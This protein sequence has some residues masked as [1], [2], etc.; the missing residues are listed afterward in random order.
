MPVPRVGL[1]VPLVTVPLTALE[2]PPETAIPG[3]AIPE[4]R[5]SPQ[6]SRDGAA[7]SASSASRPQ[8][9]GFFQPTAQPSRAATGT[10]LGRQVLPVQRISH[11]GAQRVASTEPARHPAGRDERVPRS[12]SRVPAREQL[13]AALPGVAGPADDDADRP[14]IPP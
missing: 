9:A 4:D 8:K 12:L 1:N 5:R 13:V 3:R 11:L 6:S 7:R 14:S 10:D 2:W